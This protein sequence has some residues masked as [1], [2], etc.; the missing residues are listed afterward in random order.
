MSAESWT[1]VS[2]LVVAI[3]G[4]YYAIRAWQGHVDPNPV[5]WGVW[6]FVGVALFLTADSS[7]AGAVYWSALIGAINPTVIAAVIFFRSKNRTY[8]LQA[9]E[10]WCLILA[11]MGYAFWFWV[12]NEPAAASWSLYWMIFVDLF[13][14]WPT[15][16]Q[17]LKDPLSDKPFPWIV[18]GIGYGLSGFAIETHTV[19]NWALTVYMLA[20]GLTIS[21]PMIIGRVRRGV[22][23]VEWA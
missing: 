16:V 20:G 3:S 2:A 1:Y 6:A 4:A 11:A 15:L 14:V 12:R 5:S 13:A 18:F 8:S 22:P 9:H 7:E 17:V 21:L 23:I 19:A 10:K